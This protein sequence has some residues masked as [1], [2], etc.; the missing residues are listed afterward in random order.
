MNVYAKTYRAEKLRATPIAVAALMVA[1]AAHAAFANVMPTSEQSYSADF[2]FALSPGSETLN[3]PKFDDHSGTWTLNYVTLTLNGAIYADITGENDSTISA[4][5]IASL[6][7]LLKASTNGVSTTSVIS[8]SS[9]PA[10]VTAKDGQPNGGPDFHNFG[11]L[12]N[13][14][15]SSTTKTSGL[16]AFI[17]TGTIPVL[18]NGLGGF[19]ISGT[20]DSTLRTSNFHGLGDVVV[21]YGYTVPEPVTVA[22][23]LAGAL[24]MLRRRWA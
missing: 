4:N 13:S 10:A 14:D 19:S 21:T 16:S 11:T 6:T 17:G 1:L 12:G 20:T 9:D 7:G 18:V 8:M 3:L 22:L 15:T 24:P 23:L 5:M 2:N